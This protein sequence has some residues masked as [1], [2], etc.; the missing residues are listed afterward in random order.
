MTAFWDRT[1]SLTAG[2]YPL[3]PRPTPHA[4]LG[5]DQRVQVKRKPSPAGYCHPPTGR[6]AGRYCYLPA[7]SEPYLRL[8]PHTAQAFTNA[9]CGTRP[10]L[11]TAFT[12]RASSRRT[13]RQTFFHSMECQSG[14]RSGV[15]PAGI[16]AADISAC[17]PESVGQGS[18][19]TEHLREVSSLS[20]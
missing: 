1:P 11:S 3:A 7:P 5:W 18:L 2:H 9:P 16:S 8:A 20:R 14:A 13:V 17:L 6:V 19:V 15:A 12:I 10:L 4:A